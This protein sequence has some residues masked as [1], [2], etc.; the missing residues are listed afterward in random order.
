MPKLIILFTTILLTVRLFGQAGKDM[1][2]EIKASLGSYI[3]SGN[4]LPFWLV[5]NQNGVFSLKNSSYQLVQLGIERGLRRDSLKK[6]DIFYG[7]NLVYGYAGKSDFQFNQYWLGARYKW[8]IMKAGAQ[9]DPVLYAGLSST[10]GNM[11]WSNNARPLPGIAFSTDGFIPFFFWKKWLTVKAFYAEYILFDNQ[12]IDNAHLHHKYAIARASLDSW[13]I[14]AGLDHWVFWGGTSPVTGSLP[15]F[16]SY[17]RYIFGLRGS[18]NSSSI[19]RGNV[20]G[21]SLGLY[22]LTVE[23]EYPN[24]GITFYY[25][26]PFEDRSGLEMDNIPDGLWGIYLHR[27]KG[28]AFLQD[29][30]YELQNTTN[31]SGTYNGLVIVSTGRVTGRGNDNYFN[32]S[33]YKSGF[34]HYDRMMGSPFFIPTIDSSGISKGFKNNRIWVHHIGLSGWMS[35]RLS[36]KSYLSWSR[37]LG[38]YEPNGMF[39]HALNQFSFL[40]ECSYSLNRTPL[41]LKAGIAGDYGEYQERR[42]GGYVGLEWRIR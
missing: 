10:N 9:S 15:G 2:P 19:D 42:L 18:R 20:V 16:K 37:N 25:N 36:W 30:V 1:S 22:L 40:A 39:P 21:N 26:H 34:V 7:G 27:K 12:Y 14:S 29:M 35:E 33:T 11:D 6:W 41:R 28:K 38:T 5:S 17:L 13:K 31:Q 32:H 24:M 3:S 23:K 8:L 4:D